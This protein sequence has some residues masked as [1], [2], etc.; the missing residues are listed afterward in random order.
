EEVVPS[1]PEEL[2]WNVVGDFNDWTSFD[3][4]YNEG[5]YTAEPTI[6][7]GQGFKLRLGDDWLDENGSNVPDRGLVWNEET[8]AYNPYELG[9]PFA[10]AQGGANIVVAVSGV[11]TISYDVV[12]D[13]VTVVLKEEIADPEPEPE[14]EPG[15]YTIYAHSTDGWTNMNI[16]AWDDSTNYSGGTWPGVAMTANAK[17]IDGKT[18]Y[19][20]TMP[21]DADGKTIYVIFNNGTAQTNDSIEYTLDRDLY[22]HA[23]A[24]LA[25]VLVDITGGEDGGEDSGDVTPVTKNVLLC[26]AHNSWDSAAQDFFTYN[27]TLGLYY[28]TTTLTA[29]SPF[30]VVVDGTWLGSSVI[31]IDA[32]NFVKLEAIEGGD[33]LSITSGGTFDFYY[34]DKNAYLYV[35]EQGAD[36]TTASMQTVNGAEPVVDAWGLVG[37]SINNWGNGGGDDI[38]LEWD[39]DVEMYAAKNVAFTIAASD[40]G[41]KIRQ[42][43]DS[44]WTV[45]YGASASSQPTVLKTGSGEALIKGGRNL[46]VPA[47]GTY[48]FYF[49]LANKKAYL[50]NPGEV[51]ATR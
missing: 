38:K 14:P 45:D 34:D 17:E 50:M 32:G 20:Y 41:F 28:Y 15:Q 18:Y 22:F 30:K 36:P 26:G 9:V 40:G 19:G 25:P 39:Y 44:N 11:Y 4:T 10:V 16:W 2:N 31:R 8:Q 48:D 35:M 37:K 1:Y 6:Y 13:M 49:D 24:G 51:P 12:K 21:V 42:Y 29:Y 33:N 7:A 47:A 46:E 5:I 23:T 3:M 43:N 27:E